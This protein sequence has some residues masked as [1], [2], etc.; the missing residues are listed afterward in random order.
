MKFLDAGSK[1]H[2]SVARSRSLAALYG[3]ASTI[4]PSTFRNSFI[5]EVK[6]QDKRGKGLG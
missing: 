6:V 4:P 1:F 3:H 2:L 5:K